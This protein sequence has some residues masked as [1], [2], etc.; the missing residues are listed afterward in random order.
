MGAIRQ[1]FAPTEWFKP[2]WPLFYAFVRHCHDRRAKVSPADI[3]HLM[4]KEGIAYADAE[5]MATIYQ[6]CRAVLGTRYRLPMS[7]Y[8]E[9]V[10]AP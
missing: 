4:E 3:L 1:R 2:D 6:H 8:R 5:V 10:T 7:L 9:N